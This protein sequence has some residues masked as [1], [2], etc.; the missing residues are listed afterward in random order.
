MRRFVIAAALAA[1]CTSAKA[2]G[3]QSLAERIAGVRDGTVAFHFAARAGVCGVGSQSVRIGH[4]Y[5][6]S[7][8]SGMREQACETGPV[9]VRVTTR[10]GAASSSTWRKCCARASHSPACT[11]T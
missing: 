11:S 8:Q 9:Q 10:D 6:G 4:S 7:F 3:A 2:L 1:C 5:I